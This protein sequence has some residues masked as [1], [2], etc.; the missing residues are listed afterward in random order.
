MFCILIIASNI[1]TIVIVATI[2]SIVM[3]VMTVD[4]RRLGESIRG[5]GSY[6]TSCS[7][8]IIATIPSTLHCTDRE[9]GNVI[10]DFLR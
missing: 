2:I 3:I 7:P 10:N 8:P 1:I 6:Y 9:E 4:M 5:M